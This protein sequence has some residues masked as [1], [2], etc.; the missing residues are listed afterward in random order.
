MRSMSLPS[1]HVLTACRVAAASA[2]ACIAIA[3]CAQPTDADFTAARDAYRAGDAARLERIA[4]RLAGYLLEPYVAYWRLRLKLDDADPAAVRAFLE[5]YADL[6]L[7]ERLRGEWLKA[8]GRRGEWALFAAEYPKLVAEDVELAC[9]AAQ[10]R[11]QHKDPGQVE[12]AAA[13]A[14]R[15]W[16]SG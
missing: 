10:F 15:F 6:P 1:H 3:V 5:R 7:A 16:F 11:A 13:D 14:R 4:P 12:G 8:L 9:Y 2:T